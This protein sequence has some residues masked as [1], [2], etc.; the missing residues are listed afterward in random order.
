MI[1]HR[2]KNH[3]LVLSM[4]ELVSSAIKVERR[5]EATKMHLISQTAII[6]Y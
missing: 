5:H 6:S 2:D 3:R 1:F 4:S